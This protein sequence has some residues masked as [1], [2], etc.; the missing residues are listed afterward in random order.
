[1]IITDIYSV[2]RHIE[3]PLNYEIAKN[4]K[5]NLTFI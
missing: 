1:M 3:L 5:K 4:E 2:D